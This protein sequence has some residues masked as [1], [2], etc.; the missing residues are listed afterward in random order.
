[1]LFS[2][3]TDNNIKKT[4]IKESK[5]KREIVSLIELLIFVIKPAPLLR[6]IQ[7]VLYVHL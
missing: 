6:L 3:E 2:V 1:M 7:I 5:L 4:N